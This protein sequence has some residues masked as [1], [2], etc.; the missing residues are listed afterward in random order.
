MTLIKSIS[1]IRGTIGGKPGNGLT[2]LDVVKFSSAYAAW[3]QESLNRKGGSIIIGRDARISGEMVEQL[4]C[5]SLTGMG[6]DVVNLGMAT[7]PTVEVA[8]AA[9]K[10]QGGIILTASH[11]PGHWNAL[12]LLNNRGEFI[13]AEEGQRILELAEE[14]AF[15]YA[16]QIG[17]VTG[18]NDYADKHIKKILNLDLVNTDAITEAGLRVV[19]DCVNSVGGLVLPSL[20]KQLGVVEVIELHCEP[21]GLFPHDPEPLP[22]NLEDL[23]NAVV[24]H[25][26]DLGLAV[27]PDVDRLAFV[28]EK[29]D[30]FGEEY[31]LVAVADYILGN[32]PG[33]TVSNL[34]STRALRDITEKH[35]GSYY[36]SAVG[37]VNV[38][39]VMKQCNAVIGGE[40]NGGVI[41]PEMHYGRDALTG[42]AL[43]LSHLALKGV[44]TSQLREGYPDY[45][46]SKNKVKLDPAVELDLILERVEEEYG[47][48][49]ISREDG[50]KVDMPDGWIHLRR[51]NTE[52][53]L[54]IYTEA[55]SEH[56]AEKMANEVIKLMK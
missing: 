21:N 25:G 52:P 2:P 54:R 39:Q 16:E 30:M 43:F 47:K 28:D 9:E 18:I 45:F 7:T 4:V 26:A 34:S 29:G 8:V 19:V 12:K 56:A 6:M 41:Y 40:G 27:D 17:G 36:A 51:S 14:E 10:A 55:R 31:T 22:K 13:S 1:G 5:G 42:T 53:I 3:V 37:E 46:I 23:S 49:T 32:S 35:G 33:N 15:V 20:L 38:V 50:L 24:M 11:N 44:K 48:F